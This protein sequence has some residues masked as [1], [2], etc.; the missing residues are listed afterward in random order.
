MIYEFDRPIV[1]LEEKIAELQRFAREKAIDLSNEIAN[2]EKRVRELKESIYGNLS[3][4][5]KVL[6][7][8]HPERP[9][10]LDYINML[11]ADFLEF[12]GDRCFGDDPAVV[13]GIARFRGRPVTVIG[14]LKGHDTKENLARNFG[15]AHPEGYRKA[16]RLMYQAEK[17]HRPVLAFIDTPGA[18]PGMGAEERG[19]AEAIAR[20]IQ[21]MLILRTPVIA[22]ILGEGGSGGAL[23]LAAGDRILMQEHAVFSVISPE[24]YASILWKDATRC[25]E[26]AGEMKITA[27]DLYAHHLIDEI[28]PEPLGGAHRDGKEAARLVG[29]ALHRHLEELVNLPVE[30]LLERRYQ[31]FRSTGSQLQAK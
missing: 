13:G 7:A 5:Q 22:V 24:A 28:I 20:S 6:I 8:R 18:Y 10:T 31:R 21:S 23:A 26:A 4:W 9:N 14:H 29:E 17:F 25:R 16:V 19:Q 27:G 12:H 1:E 3:P 30:Q 2:L 15:M 11:C